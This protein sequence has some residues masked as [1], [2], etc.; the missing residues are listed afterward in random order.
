[1]LVVTVVQTYCRDREFGSNSIDAWISAESHNSLIKT[2]L[3]I[4]H[5]VISSALVGEGLF[6]GD[7]QA[8]ILSAIAVTSPRMLDRGNLDTFSD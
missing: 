7:T 4:S 6:C 1:M 5:S 3:S 8:V 2:G